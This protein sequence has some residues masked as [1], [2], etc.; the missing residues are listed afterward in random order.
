MMYRI[1]LLSLLGWSIG[2]VFACSSMLPAQNVVTDWNAIASTTI[3]KNA[4]NG[5]SP[6]TVYFAYAAIASYDAVTAISRKSQPFYYFHPASRRASV[7]AA[8]V[9]AS[10]RVLV[11]YFPSQQAML[12]QQFNLSLAAIQASPDAKAAG[13]DVGEA[14]AAALIAARTGDGV[15]AT[16]TYTPG[17]G[18][19]AWQRTPPGF[20]NPATP[21]LGEMRPFTMHSASQFLPEGPTPLGSAE[22][23]RDYNLTRMLGAANGS[24]RTPKQ[25]EIGIF[26]TENTAQQY[27]RLF[28]NLASQ[29]HLNL[30]ETAR[31]MAMLWTGAADAAIGCYNAKYHYG[32]WRPVTAIPAG[33]GNSDLTADPNWLPLGTTPNHPEYPAAHACLTGAVTNLIAGY[34]GTFK[35]PMAVESLAFQDGIH[36]HSFNDTRDVLEEVK[37]AR[38]YS[39]FH[40]YDSVVAGGQLG[41]NVA[42]HLQRRYFRKF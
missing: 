28:N 39:G 5:P 38:I 20:Q 15:A 24:I 41:K 21:W 10:H 18:P 23:E 19:G 4:G 37:W 29:H 36:T 17:T 14:S 33:G 42:R 16:V 30:P 25:T 12:D 3:I 22:W 13:V 1:K 35:L 27:A 31:F 40:F 7:E 34:F 32:F 6:G 11:N 9:A 8:A 26:W 2:I